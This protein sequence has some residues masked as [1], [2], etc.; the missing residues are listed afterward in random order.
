MG[1]QRFATRGRTSLAKL[2][3]NNPRKR[4]SWTFE[5]LEDRL[6]FSVSPNMQVISFSSDN[7]EG[8]ALTAAHEMYWAQSAYTGTPDA[9]KYTFMSLPTDPMFG[10]QWHLLNVGQEVGNPDLQNLFG[11]AGED[12][13]VV[14][15]WNFVD[16]NG[17]PIRGDGIFVAVIDSGVQLF[18]PDLAGNISPILRFNSANGTNNVNPDLSNNQSYHGTAVAGII[19]AVSDNAEGGVG[20]A[21]GVTLVPI[22][23]DLG[24]GISDQSLED[25]LLYAMSHDVDITNNSFGPI[26]ARQAVPLSPTLL[27]TLRDAVIFGRDGKGMIN[28]FAAGNNAGAGFDSTGQLNSSSYN[29]ILNSRYVIGV[30]GVDHD[31]LYVNADG[32][33][34][35]YPVA[36]PNVLVAAPTGS[37]NGNLVGQD[38]GFGSGIWTT[39]LFGD[40]GRNADPLPNGSD[41][42]R[43]PFPDANYTS[44]Y[45]GTSASAAMVSGVVA[46]MLQAN[47]NL[48]FRDVEEILVRSA[49]QN[50]PMEYPSTGVGSFGSDPTWQ[51]NQ[52]GPFRNPDLHAVFGNPNYT[53]PFEAF[54]DPIAD[55]DANYQFF[56]FP[57]FGPDTNDGGRQAASS[58]EPQP[59][60][61][62][63]GA[64]Y[65]VSQGYGFYG[66]QIGYGHGVVDAAEAVYMAL[67][68][69]GDSQHASQFAAPELTFTTA[70]QGVAAPIPAAAKGADPPGGNRILVPGG[71]GGINAIAYWNQYF[72]T[73]PFNNYTGP[74]DLDRGESYIDFAVPPSQE[75]NIEQVEVK[76]N[77][78]GAGA[79]GTGLNGL[80]V[81]LVS[82]DGTQSELNHYYQDGS[83][84]PYLEQPSSGVPTAQLGDIINAGG[85]N[86]QW[87]FTTNR[88]WGES[89][90]AQ[91]ITHP[92]T[93]EPLLS[94]GLPVFRNWELHVENWSN[95]PFTFSNVEIIWH[96]KPIGNGQFDPN[97]QDQGILKGQRV[98]GSVGIDQNGDN[99]FN[100]NRYVQTVFGTHADQST[101]RDSDVLRTPDFTD[102]NNNFIFDEG[103]VSNQEV[104]AQ[105]IWVDAYKVWNGVQEAQPFASF[106]TGADGNYYFD[107]DVNGD[108]AQT[109]D[110]NNVHFGQTIEYK[111][112]VTDQQGINTLGHQRL[113]LE[114]LATNDPL[115]TTPPSDPN[116]TFLQHY[117]QT[118][119]INPNWF[120][121]PDRDN[122]LPLGNNP[123]EVFFDATGTITNWGL[124]DN[125]DVPFPGLPSPVPWNNFG[126]INH[127]VPA[128]VK[129]INFL[130]KDDAPANKFDVTGFV[131][132]DVNGNGEFDGSDAPINGA[133]VYWD[134][135]RNGAH[136]AGEPTVLTDAAGRYFITADLT[137]LPVIPSI[138]PDAPYQFGVIKPSSDWTF[139]DPGG[140]GV[141]TV[142]ASAGSPLQNI[143][144]FLKPPSASPPTGAGPG[145]V[146]GIVF[147]DLDNDGI[148]DA[149]E[150]GVPNIQVFIDTDLDGAFDPGETTTTTASN[151]SYFFNNINA[152]VYRIDIVIPNE[153]LPNAAWSINAPVAGFR[154]IQIFEGGNQQG[155]SFALHN[156]ASS[157]WGDLPNSFDTT[158]ATNGPSHNVV[159]WFRLGNTIDGEVDGIPSNDALGDAIIGDTDDGVAVVSNGGF[160]KL[161]VNTLR[162]TTFGVGGQL[163]G[164]M[165]FNNDQQFSES[166]R[167]TW[168]L[169]GNNLG[170]EADLS[171]GTFDLQI[172]IPANAVDQR[173]IAA[174]FRW[175]EAGLSFTGHAGIGE[176]EDYLFGLNFLFGDYNKNGVVDAADFPIWKKTNGAT[177]ITP[178]SGADGDGDGDVDQDDFIVWQKNFGKML[179]PPGAGAIVAGTSN[180][181]SS[182][183]ASAGSSLA[184]GQSMSVEGSNLVAGGQSTGVLPPAASVPP[185]K[186]PEETVSMPVIA[187]S[188]SSFSLAPQL[189][190][191]STDTGNTMGGGLV[192]TST[193]IVQR[194]SANSESS[195]S[196]LLLLDDAWAGLNGNT[197]DD[198][199]DESL[200]DGES[201]ETVCT[202]DLALAAVL[203]EDDDWWSSL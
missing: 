199:A 182:N 161:G 198:S 159:P 22:K 178:Y 4:R 35:S 59:A 201:H 63:N 183:P 115:Q 191:F 125:T 171:P 153:G 104:F 137:T 128:P 26:Q 82:P 96:G 36:G 202:N 41:P 101:I 80:R 109:Q 195:D 78:G 47:P 86:F 175:G 53:N 66:E 144:F 176:V 189:V 119:T 79:A 158:A 92:V 160:L 73:P 9:P 99:L 51:V 170:G 90:N 102:N 76:I 154:E 116:F 148:Q 121:A 94:N 62:A 93:G 142:F 33:F 32:T 38:D 156:R 60:L 21:P 57:D 8:A 30:T 188:G 39:D 20:V 15:A 130:I 139:T 151:G 81:M 120:F 98:Q 100:F 186:L 150:T 3:E 174:R 162:V 48:T 166:E 31:G 55:P 40:F 54:L 141:E 180:S 194:A 18:H 173:P 126:Q 6:V 106:L 44:R 135:D 17:N 165:D 149:G 27:Q 64:G 181:S 111:I 12:I 129:N 46:L 132:S 138:D 193:S 19:G 112:G 147:N 197:Y 127:I 108:V 196:N 163:T 65:T 136:D 89:S 190:I 177:G 69:G 14:D 67:N 1:H 143:N 103:D 164:W 45:Q 7:P 71:I 42:D 155:V 140:D 91:V 123:G 113:L 75:M 2:A 25:A 179:P 77:F 169:N 56:G 37:N 34:T 167:L 61:F 43:D 168:T 110:I 105:N 70:L 107:F 13:H 172:T 16:A 72:A 122:P 117:K 87:T 49:R 131:Y 114:D 10:N 23:A 185:S 124:L 203:K 68:W 95:Q 5:R 52:T 50:A 118:W 200:Y 58:Y 192:S 28:I 83:F 145:S 184:A 134:K 84:I 146:Q 157:D 187:A 152:G 97:Y 24:F 85:G 88:H 11:V 133:T 74:I 29:G